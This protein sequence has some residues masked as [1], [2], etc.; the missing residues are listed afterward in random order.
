MRIATSLSLFA[1]MALASPF[2]SAAEPATALLPAPATQ[3]EQAASPAA[4]PAPAVVIPANDTSR[5]GTFKHVEGEVWLARSAQRLQPAAGDGVKEAERLQTGAAGAA[6]IQLKDGTVLTMG[7]NT[8]MDLSRFNFDSTTQQGHFVLD[9]L[10]GSVRVITGLLARI[11][12]ELFKVQT[13][14]SVVGVRGTDFIV[15]AEAPR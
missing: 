15:H 10:Q 2:A 6:S 1:A 12:P 4:E 5:I 14:T 8:T 11:N 9:L 13:P 3:A 7:P